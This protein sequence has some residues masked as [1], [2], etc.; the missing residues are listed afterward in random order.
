M[1]LIGFL[2]DALLRKTGFPDILFLLLLGIF[3]GPV[4]GVFSKDDLM[5]IT[6]YLVELSLIMIL[7][8]GGMEMNLSKVLRQSG[9]AALLAITYFLFVTIAVSFVAKFILNLDW[10]Q[11]IMLGPMIAGTSSIVII[12]LS[13]KLKISEET[14][15]TL[16]LESTITDVLN[17]VLF[18]SI[19]G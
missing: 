1:L 9:R 3:F 17:I 11:A 13:K 2:A 7:F 8:Y 5:P 4:L 19:L 12:P 10:I 15:L 6:P 16:S 18:F 14:S